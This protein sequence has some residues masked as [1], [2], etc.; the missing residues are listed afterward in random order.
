MHTKLSSVWLFCFGLWRIEYY[1]PSES[2]MNKRQ[3]EQHNEH[4]LVAFSLP[5]EQGM[6]PQT[7]TSPLGTSNADPMLN[8]CVEPPAEDILMCLCNSFPNTDILQDEPGQIDLNLTEF[9]FFSSQSCGSPV[10]L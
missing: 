3:S 1:F 9:S 5:L 7:L 6:V 2:A 8:S 10:F 4:S